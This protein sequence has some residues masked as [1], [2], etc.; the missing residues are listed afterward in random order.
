MS[1][2]KKICLGILSFLPLLSTTIF[3]ILIC[4][5]YFKMIFGAISGSLVYSDES[6][7]IFIVVMIVCGILLNVIV[8]TVL[9]I[10][11]ICIVK[12]KRIEDTSKILYLIG[13]YF[14]YT[15]IPI[16]Y[17]FIEVLG[18]NEKIEKIENIIF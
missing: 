15:I 13:L 16:I 4:L 3:I 1:K 8:Y 5:F 10:F 11:T 2:T 9:I 6:E 17:F 12:N 18:E 14:L 7:I